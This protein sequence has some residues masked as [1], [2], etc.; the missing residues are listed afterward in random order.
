M[1]KKILVICAVGIMFLNNA[2]FAA[3]QETNQQIML[4]ITA[5]TITLQNSD[6]DSQGKAVVHI[7]N[8]GPGSCPSPYVSPAAKYPWVMAYPSGWQVGIGV[9]N[10]ISPEYSGL[11]GS[12][13]KPITQLLVTPNCDANGCNLAVAFQYLWYSNML[14]DQLGV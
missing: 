10:V 13:S 12:L 8:F 7:N 1:F 14:P 4:P 5:G 3:E 9:Y 6:F 11:T 2:I